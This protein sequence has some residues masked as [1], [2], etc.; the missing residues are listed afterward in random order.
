VW[1]AM[2]EG[3]PGEQ[4]RRWRDEHFRELI[5]SGVHDVES[6]RVLRGDATVAVMLVWVRRQGARLLVVPLNGVP[7]FPTF[8]FDDRGELRAELSGHVEA[9]QEADFSP[10]QTSSWLVSPTGQLSSGVPAEMVVS[11]PVR[12][13]KAVQRMLDQVR[14]PEA[15]RPS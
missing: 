3:E 14:G 13:A 10:W 4:Q 2:S 8:Q 12:A 7:V 6:L 15:G 5:A 9:L 1:C 11:H